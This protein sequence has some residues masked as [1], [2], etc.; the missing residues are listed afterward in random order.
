MLATALFTVYTT[1]F[2][3]TAPYGRH[4]AGA[5]P[6]WGFLVNPRVAWAV[7]ESPNLWWC[8]YFCLA[9]GGMVAAGGAPLPAANRALVFMFAGHYVNRALVYPLRLSRGSKDMP[10]TVMLSATF[11]CTWNGYIQAK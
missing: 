9:N 10:V 2:V 6:R 1:L 11:Y 3:V 7:M 5:G 8:L 4:A